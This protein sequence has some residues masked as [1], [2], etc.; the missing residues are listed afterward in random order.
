MHNKQG[1]VLTRLL[2]NLHNRWGNVPLTIGEH[3]A[4]FLPIME[5]KGGSNMSSCR[6]TN[7]YD[8]EW[9]RHTDEDTVH[10]I[11]AWSSFYPLERRPLFA[12]RF[13]L[14]L[15]WLLVALLMRSI[16]H[17]KVY[18]YLPNIMQ[19]LLVII[20]VVMYRLIFQ[21]FPVFWN[22]NHK[23]FGK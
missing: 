22:K 12:H 16:I 23:Y 4:I 17:R 18:A 6:I 14:Q 10:S 19:L 2:P 7:W 1:S 11:L 20:Y 21:Q 8:Q 3:W 9:S 15:L 5:L 13:Y